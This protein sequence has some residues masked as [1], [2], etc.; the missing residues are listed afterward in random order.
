MDEI[1]TVVKI[2]TRLGR[3]WAPVSTLTSAPIS[4]TDKVSYHWYHGIVVPIP[5]RPAAIWPPSHTFS[6]RHYHDLLSLLS[7]SFSS[8]SFSQ[9]L[10]SSLYFKLQLSWFLFIPP[11]NYFFRVFPFLGWQYGSCVSAHHFSSLSSLKSRI[12]WRAQTFGV[13]H[14]VHIQ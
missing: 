3:G 8:V 2:L 4:V 11:D 12:P 9:D 14:T 5:A 10:R 6:I 1:R 7:N 13:Y